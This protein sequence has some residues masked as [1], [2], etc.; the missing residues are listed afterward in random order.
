MLTDSQFEGIML[1]V[2]YNGVTILDV[3]VDHYES[4]H[5]SLTFIQWWGS[6]TADQK[7]SE[8]FDILLHQ[9]GEGFRANKEMPNGTTR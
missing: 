9:Y 4:T 8:V 2:A 3:V 1:E 7:R 6:L 5:Q